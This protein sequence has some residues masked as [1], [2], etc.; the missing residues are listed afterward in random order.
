[1][2]HPTTIIAEGA[3]IDASATVGPYCVIEE[4]VQIGAE[5][6]LKSHVCVHRGSILEEAVRVSPFVVIGDN[7]QSVGFDPSIRSGVRVARGTVLRENVTIH[8]GSK[9]GSMTRIGEDCFLM[10][11]AHVAHDCVVEDKVIMANNSLL[12]GHV[13]VGRNAFLGGGAMF[14]QFTRIGQG[15]MIAGGTEISYDVPPYITVAVRNAVKG[16]NLIGLRRQRVSATAIAELKNL[17]RLIF[18]TSG[19]FPKRL[20][21]IENQGALPKT[22]EGKIFIEFFRQDGRGFV[23]VK[24]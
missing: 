17:Y 1:M 18:Y 15:A 11:G 22:E 14:H 24:D 23:K 12:G 21:E 3:K 10:A 7:P 19:S 8:R 20:T 16:L 6:V 13:K 9:E 2:I 4:G 5:C